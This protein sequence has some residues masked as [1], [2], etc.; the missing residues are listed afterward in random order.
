MARFITRTSLVAE[1]P[2]GVR[3]M[4]MQWSDLPAATTTFWDTD[5]SEDDNQYAPYKPIPTEDCADFIHH[6]TGGLSNGPYWETRVKDPNPGGGPGSHEATASHKFWSAWS[7]GAA[8][9]LCISFTTQF[10]SAYIARAVAQ[11]S[12]GKFLLSQM[13]NAA[14]TGTESGD[15]EPC[16]FLQEGDQDQDNDPDGLYF[17]IANHG[18]GGSLQNDGVNTPLR[19]DSRPGEKLWMGWVLDF[20]AASGDNRGVHIFY[21]YEGDAGITKSCFRSIL[22]NIN[23]AGTFI[24]PGMGIASPD[25]SDANAAFWGYLD[26]LEGFTAAPGESFN[27]YKIQSGNGRFALPF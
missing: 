19:V 26:N 24:D 13:Y 15:A 11:N 27:M 16:I 17:G 3:G 7:P 23:F 10:N 2:S 12:G 25:N 22:D 20:E 21:K 6:T 8:R 18:A 9:L 1:A 5:Y 4:N 14:G